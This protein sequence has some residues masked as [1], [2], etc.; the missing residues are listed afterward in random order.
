LTATS[1][2]RPFDIRQGPVERHYLAIY[3][4]PSAAR[5][6]PPCSVLALLSAR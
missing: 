3:N 2:S 5:R 6:V 1:L 4:P